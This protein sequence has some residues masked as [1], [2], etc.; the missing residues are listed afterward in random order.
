MR[1]E[2]HNEEEEEEETNK[3]NTLKD[4]EHFKIRRAWKCHKNETNNEEVEQSLGMTITTRKRSKGKNLQIMDLTFEGDKDEEG[5][6]RPQ[7]GQN[8]KVNILVC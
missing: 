8:C 2:T 3:Q 6:S 4:D 1:I 7:V 5:P